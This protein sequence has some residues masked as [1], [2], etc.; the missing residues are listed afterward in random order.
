MS[1]V[2]PIPFS[3]EAEQAVVGAM[4]ARP[5]VIAEVIGSMI[6]AQHFHV[7]AHRLLFETLVDAYFGDQTIDA[8]SI[9]STAGPALRQAWQTDEKDAVERCRQI[10]GRAIPHEAVSNAQVVK[11]DSDR[12]QLLEIAR[13]LEAHVLAETKA[14]DELAA[15]AA[16]RAMEVATSRIHA[17]DILDFATLG[18]NYITTLKEAKAAFEQGIELG[19]KFGW[20]FMDDYLRGLKGSDLFLVAGEPGVGKSWLTWLAALAFAG[21]QMVKPVEQRI[22]TFV[23]SLEMAEEPSSARLA[24][25]L[26]GVDGGK[27]REGDI[28]NDELTRIIRQWGGRKDLPL[29]FNFTSMLRASQLRALV[30]EAIRRHNVGLVIIDHMR[31]FDADRKFDNRADEDEEKA[32][33]LKESIAKDLDVAVICLAHTTKAIENTDDGRP[34]L[35]HL[36]GSGQVAA[37]ADFVAFMYQAYNHATE[38]DIATGAVVRTDAELIFAKNRHGLMGSSEFHFDPSSGL[39]RDLIH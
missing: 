38:N 10:A 35:S 12:R 14:P 20:K 26:G 7:P 15:N 23:L 29:Y 27:L 1:G 28:T 34:R 32:R 5:K 31:Y 36:R 30:V 18:R 8:V 13:D 17:P 25:S 16:Q 37:H 6:Q 2:A 3:L 22:G 33:F 24:Q 39:V 11:R 19:V 21:R 4:L 9:A